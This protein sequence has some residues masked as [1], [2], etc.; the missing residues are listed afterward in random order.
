[1][2]KFDKEIVKLAKQSKCPVRKEYEEEIDQLLDKLK[3]EETKA[4]KRKVSVMSWRKV[5]IAACVAV[6]VFC[7]SMP[8]AAEISDY[9]KERISQMSEEEQEQYRETNDLEK[10]TKE[11]ETEAIKYSRELSKEE[12]TRY[13]QLSEKY[14][15]EGLFPEG[16]MQ[17]VEKLE[18][19]AK[20]TALLYEIYNREFYLPERE[21]TDEELLQLVDFQYKLVYSVSQ[22]QDVQEILQGQKEFYE[23]PY[24]GENDMSEEE[25]IEKAAAYLKGMCDVD[26]DSMEKTVEFWLG[27]GI[28][29][30]GDYNVTFKDKEKNTYNVNLNGETGTLYSIKLENSL[31]TLTKSKEISE[32]LVVT[33]YE[34][35]K[36]IFAG[37]LGEEV[38]VVS[39]SC[40]YPVDEAG[41]MKVGS[42]GVMTYIFEL[43]N[44]E[45]YYIDYDSEHD[46]FIKMYDIFD[47]AS[48]KK[49]WEKDVIEEEGNKMITMDGIERIAVISMEE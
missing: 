41:N 20:I 4:G 1:M 15:E 12:E 14:K 37:V 30:Y 49:L 25:A 33:N 44:G 47:Y 45:A 36:N 40:T 3:S 39:S 19:N 8:V 23:N 2:N 18:E 32:E 11:H 24:P 46:E 31:I 22:E 38:K 35:A 21:L 42:V 7:V 29:D 16:E 10:L 17:R 34:K 6:T 28:E 48:E 9:V 26:T 27:E 5:S 43:E 13:Q